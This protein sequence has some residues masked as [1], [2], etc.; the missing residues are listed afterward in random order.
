MDGHVLL[1]MRT[2]MLILLLLLLSLAA[3]EAGQEA[4]PESIPSAQTE[5]SSPTSKTTEN[6]PNGPDALSSVTVEG[7]RLEIRPKRG[8]KGTVPE[9]TISSV[10]NLG[11]GWGNPYKLEVRRSGQWI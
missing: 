8:P 4:T 3:C 7:F 9:A 1:G 2:K 5:P 11:F 10:D 6:D